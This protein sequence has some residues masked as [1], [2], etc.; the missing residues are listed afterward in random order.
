MEIS[1]YEVLLSDVETR[2]DRVRALYEQYFQGI[3][4]IEPTIA[5][6]EMDRRIAQLRRGKPR[7]TALRFRFNT[8]V[9][10][11]TTYQNYWRRVVRQIEEGT[12]RRHLDRARARKRP[13]PKPPPQA[14]LSPA[15]RLQAATK[16]IPSVLPA[17]PEPASAPNGAASALTPFARSSRPGPPPVPGAAGP[18]VPKAPPVPAPGRQP[19]PPRPP[20]GAP[21]PAGAGAQSK[22]AR[23]GPDD[24]AMRQL[25]NEYVT[26]RKTHNQKTEHLKYEAVAK[27][28]RTMVPELQKKHR[29]KAIDFKVVV[30]DGKVGLKPVLK[31]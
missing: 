13:T 27:K 24:Q 8:L 15:E 18:A 4:R 7:N 17:V 16:T 20:P 22:G 2:L 31:G 26:A 30:K 1:E 6:K 21:R 12:Y 25:Y 10:K 3:E 11:Y 14:E 28:I 19:G 9:Q 5:R 23:G 29:G